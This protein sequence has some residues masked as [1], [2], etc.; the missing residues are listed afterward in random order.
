M[1]RESSADR[2]SVAAMRRA[3]ALGIRGS[4]RAERKSEVDAGGR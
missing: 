4:A 3:E 2:H 1:K